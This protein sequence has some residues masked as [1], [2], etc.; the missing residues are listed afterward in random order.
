MSDAA[1]TRVNWTEHDLVSKDQFLTQTRTH[2]TQLVSLVNVIETS[3]VTLDFKVCSTDALQPT[4]LVSNNAQSAQYP[5]GRN[6]NGF[7]QKFNVLKKTLRPEIDAIKA[8]VPFDGANTTLKKTA[9]PKKPAA[10]KSDTPRKRK[11]S[12]SDD[13]SEDA[14][15]KKR[16]RPKKVV[17]KEEED[18]DAGLDAQNEIA[19]EDD[20]MEAI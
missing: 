2:I 17:K 4:R 7:S 13:G 9:T 19:E 6:A 3:G 14:A 20:M 5:V 8:G 15:P 1:H 12:K 16:G 18:A 11:A 10:P